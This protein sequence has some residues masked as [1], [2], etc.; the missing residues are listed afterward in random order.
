[1]RNFDPFSVKKITYNAASGTVIYKSKTTQRKSKGGR[2][3][4]Q[5]FTA[6]EFIAAITQ[7]IPEK[8]FQLVRYYGW[9]SNRGRGER[10]T[11]TSPNID[12]RKSLLPSGVNVLQ[13][14]SKSEFIPC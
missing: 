3:N 7:H 12:R 13:G 2:E 1:L 4:F 10:K 8:S 11:L 6:L 14:H 9:Y 5:V